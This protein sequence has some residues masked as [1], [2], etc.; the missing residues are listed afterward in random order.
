MAKCPECK[1][2]VVKP[3]KKWT[4]GPFEVEKYLCSKRGLEFG[5]YLQNG[6]LNFVLKGTG[7]RKPRYVKVQ[8]SS[9]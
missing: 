4:Y 8:L 3:S 6:K 9:S 7:K 1:R 2:E 5:E